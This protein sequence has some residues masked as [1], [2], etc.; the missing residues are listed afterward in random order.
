MQLALRQNEYPEPFRDGDSDYSE[1]SGE[2]ASCTDT[3]SERESMPDICKRIVIFVCISVC[4]T[5]CFF[6][7]GVI[8]SITFWYVKSYFNPGPPSACYTLPS[9]EGY[10]TI[11]QHSIQTQD[12]MSLTM[13]RVPGDSAMPVLI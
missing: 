11:S 2:D 1:F 5:G 3:D 7:M 4:T 8:A 13:W 6:V 9:K 12:G 10:P